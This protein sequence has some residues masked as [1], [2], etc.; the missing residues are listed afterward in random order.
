MVK[1]VEELISKFKVEGSTPATL[2]EIFPFFH[3][4]I[5]NI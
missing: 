1:M 3:S 5:H 4:H 2:L